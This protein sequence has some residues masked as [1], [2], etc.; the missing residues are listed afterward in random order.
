MIVAE[1]VQHAV[2]DEPRELLAHA[3]RRARA[4]CVARDLGRDVDVA[5]DRERSLDA[6]A[7]PNEITSVGPAMTEVLRGSAR[8]APRCSTKVIES[9]AS[10]TRS[11]RSDARAIVATRARASGDAHVRRRDVHDRRLIRTRTRTSRRRSRV[12]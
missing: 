12:G 8:D 5:D 9:I 1:H 2:H 4:R 3:A 7:K 6:R 10:R 11:A